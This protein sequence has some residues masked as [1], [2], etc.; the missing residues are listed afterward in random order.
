M[1]KEEYGIPLQPILAPN[2]Q[3]NAE[4]SGGFTPLREEDGPWLIWSRYWNCWHCNRDGHASGYTKDIE[5]AG[6][7]GFEVARGYHDPPPHRRDEAIALSSA[8]AD[9]EHRL[10]A[11]TVERNAFAATVKQAR[12]ALAKAEALTAQS[13]EAPGGKD[14]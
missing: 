3:C 6:V 7:F 12:A 11:M 9:L 5:R 1:S 2:G 14:E 10:A 4:R 8:L 13:S